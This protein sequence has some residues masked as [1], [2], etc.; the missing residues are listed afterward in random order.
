[1]D[2]YAQLSEC[3]TG[4]DDGQQPLRTNRGRISRNSPLVGPVK[5]AVAPRPFSKP[6]RQSQM[7]DSNQPVRSPVRTYKKDVEVDLDAKVPLPPPSAYTS[8]S[9][10][11]NQQPLYSNSPSPVPP[12]PPTRRSPPSRP[13]KESQSP[14]YMNLTSFSTHQQRP[15]IDDLNYDFPVS[16]P[17]KQNPRVDQ[18]QLYDIPRTGSEIEQQSL[19]FL[20]FVPLPPSK[21]KSSANQKQHNYINAPSGFLPGRRGSAS[22]MCSGS[23]SSNNGSSKHK[24]LYEYD[25]TPSLST[26]LS[27]GPPLPQRRESDR[28]SFESDTTG[29]SSSSSPHLQNFSSPSGMGSL[30]R[31]LRNV[32]I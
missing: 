17:K 5:P 23:S 15:Q 19:N 6:P 3:F 1:M 12:T 25:Y 30:G 13:R 26:V 11:Q 16:L 7:N 18:D 24:V 14:T 28:N 32:W 2:P 29:R 20:N 22:G 9:Q 4:G 8:S 10:P 27:G 31:K 21:S